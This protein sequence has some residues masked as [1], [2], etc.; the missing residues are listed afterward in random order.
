MNATLHRKSSDRACGNCRSY[1]FYVGIEDSKDGKTTGA[2]EL[3]RKDH[4]SNE[5]CEFWAEGRWPYR[6]YNEPEETKH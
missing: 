2:C 5:V 4:D 1:R 3:D 6:Q